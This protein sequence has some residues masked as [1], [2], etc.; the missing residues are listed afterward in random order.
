MQ[1]QLSQIQRVDNEKS[2]FNG[3]NIHTYSVLSNLYW[4][5]KIRW[6]FWIS[7]KYV[8]FHTYLYLKK[9]FFYLIHSGKKYSYFVLQLVPAINRFVNIRNTSEAIFAWN[10]LC[11]NF[12][13]KQRI[14][15]WKINKMLNEKSFLLSLI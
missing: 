6:I 2:K 3:R 14:P 5:M 15:V 11:A 7:N 1:L 10:Y 13:V 12:Q 8:E 9:L 4:I